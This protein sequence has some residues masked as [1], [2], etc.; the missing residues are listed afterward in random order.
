MSVCS[1]TWFRVRSTESLGKV[2]SWVVH[3]VLQVARGHSQRNWFR[4]DELV[5]LHGESVERVLQNAAL[6]SR[7]FAA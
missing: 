7:K 6:N 3:F 4:G 1:S 5:Q 2:R